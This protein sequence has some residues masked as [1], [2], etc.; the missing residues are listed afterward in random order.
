[1]RSIKLL[2]TVGALFLSFATGCAEVA[3]PVQGD[4][5]SGVIVAAAA[6]ATDPNAMPADIATYLADHNWSYMHLDFHVARMWDGLGEGGRD[7]AT[8][9]GISRWK[10]QE[11][12]AGTGLEFLA[13]HRLMIEELRLVF[14]HHQAL[15]DGWTTPPTDNDD[16]AGPVPPGTAAFS[17]AMREAIERIESG[18]ATFASD[19]DFALYLQTTR[20]PTADDPR[21][22]SPDR[23]AGIHNYLHNRYTDDNSPINV[24]DPATNLG[25]QV[26]WKI[27]GWVDAQWTAYRRAK[28][29]DDKTDMVYVKALA[30]AETWMKEVHSRA[31]AASKT[32]DACETV[33]DE[34]RN[35]FAD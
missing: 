13:M 5:C 4:T 9:Q 7:W 3:E 34:I 27:H 29:L 8:D 28:G 26:F 33:P 22:R 32:D 1:M 16:P 24:G 30:A 10:Q 31:H 2:S 17:A 6:E 25:N 14:P 19:D 18:Q 15:F 20:R 23:T 21:G 11:G 35:L 12:E